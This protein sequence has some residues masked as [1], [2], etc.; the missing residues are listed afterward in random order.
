MF[1][2]RLLNVWRFECLDVLMFV[3]VCARLKRDKLFYFFS[4]CLLKRVKNIWVWTWPPT[5]ILLGLRKCLQQIKF[6]LIGLLFK[7]F[8]NW[9]R[10]M[11]LFISMEFHTKNYLK[12][13]CVALELH[14]PSI[15]WQNKMEFYNL[16]PGQQCLVPHSQSSLAFLMQVLGIFS[17]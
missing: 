16:K 9:W 15:Y 14:A 4:Y 17:N 7:Q 13:L 10:C 1:D 3:P 11:E 8:S 12:K 2:P 5:N 6:V